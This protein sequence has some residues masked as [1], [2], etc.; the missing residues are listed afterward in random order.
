MKVS[1]YTL[2]LLS[3]ILFLS[4]CKKEIVSE[5]IYG[6]WMMQKQ[7]TTE[8]YGVWMMQKQTTTE[9]YGG[10]YAWGEKKT[11][12]VYNEVA[13][14]YCSG[15]DTNGDGW[16]YDEDGRLDE[17][18]NYKELGSI[19]GTKYDVAHKKWGDKWQMPSPEQI[20]ELLNNCTSTWI[21]TNGVSGRI[22]TSSNGNSIFL[23]AAGYY[24]GTSLTG[25]GN[26]GGY[27]SGQD[28]EHSAYD[29]D[30]DSDSAHCYSMSR[31]CGY[32]VRPISR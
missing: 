26:N 19:S 21:T 24:N 10:Y 32:S 18:V 6:V 25:A 16:Y 12:S 1:I 7:T 13:Y 20:V 3:C 17:I 15:T 22:F 30:F 29:L 11:K 31:S 9:G 8:G 5:D 28:S 14:K 2:S 27:W 4:S 23:P